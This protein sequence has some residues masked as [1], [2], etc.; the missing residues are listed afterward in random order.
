M[1]YDAA[2]KKFHK[3]KEEKRFWRK[4]QNINAGIKEK[5]FYSFNKNK[6]AACLK[7][8]VGVLHILFS[9]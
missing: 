4:N 6:P 2:S 8:L 9:L 1:L 5:L 3:N 7:N